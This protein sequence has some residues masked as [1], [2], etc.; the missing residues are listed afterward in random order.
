MKFYYLGIAVLFNSFGTALMAKSNLGMSTWGSAAINF[1]EF[2]NISLGIS[3]N[4]LAVVFYTVAVLISRKFSLRK[5]IYS[6]GFSLSFG[7]FTDIFIYML[8]NIEI[9]PVWLRLLINIIGLLSMCFGIALHLRINLAVH[10]IDVFL[11]TLQALVKNVAKGTYL[12]YGT[13]FLVAILFG[14]LSGSIIGIGIGTINTLLFA[15]IILGYYDK[16][17]RI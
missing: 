14:L 4:I 7:L 13:A 2:T 10:P 9:M 16:R 8:P 12:A 5:A 17:L 3:F 6:F 15:G 11:G 1:S